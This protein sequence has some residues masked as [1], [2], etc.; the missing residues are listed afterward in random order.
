MPS[1]TLDNLIA[2]RIIY[3]LVKPYTD[4]PAFKLG[5]IDKTGQKIKEPENYQEEA[6]WTMLHRLVSRLKFLLGKLPGGKSQ[7]VSMIAAYILV[8]DKPP[9]K[10]DID[11]E[12]AFEEA[13]DAVT[14]ELIEEMTPL[15]EEAIATSVGNVAG[16]GSQAP[17]DIAGGQGKNKKSLILRRGMP[18]G[19]PLSELRGKWNANTK[20]S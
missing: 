10:E 4:W 3:L 1:K 15:I 7:L 2:L 14:P 9:I 20:S 16:I 5:V 19:K 18:M 11:L 13:Y 8:K 6:S 17:D 12:S